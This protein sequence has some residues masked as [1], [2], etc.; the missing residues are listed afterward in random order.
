MN[1]WDGMFGIIGK[2]TFFNKLMTFIVKYW[3]TKTKKFFS[4]P[5][6]KAKK[7]IVPE[8]IGEITP[9][10]IAREALYL[11]NNRKHL[12]D[13]RN[14]LLK[15]RGKSGAGKK[16]AHIIINLIKKLS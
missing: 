2:I 8:R 16:L 3:N 12:Q 10:Q 7:Y 1:A 6:I 11:I 9:K 15:Q 5:N 13:L 14:N 4:W